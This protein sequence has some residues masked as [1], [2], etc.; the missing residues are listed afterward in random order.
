MS[1]APA[2]PALAVRGLR[3]GYGR[4]GDIVRGID[5]DQLPETI[6]AVIG[7]NGS[8]KSTFVKTLAGLLRPREGSISITGRDVTGLSAARR[9][10]AGVAYVPQEKNVFATLTV[11]ENMQLATEFLRRRAG[12]GRE[13]EERVLT[14]FPELADRG[15]TLAGNLSGGQ[16]QMVAFACALLAN[17]EV[18]LLDEPS[19]GLSPRFVSETMEA[20]VRVRSAGT[21][22]VL[23]EQNVQAALCIADA[24]MVLVA[25]RKSLEAPAGQ[26]RQADLAD[27]FF[28]RAA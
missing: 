5:L 17:P 2:I 28:A 10:V 15:R 18:L 3:A 8:G 26:I 6:L 20:I 13:Q 22:I 24:V 1:G 14:L 11:R 9:V 19:A 16:R 12:T 7:P 4:G 27:L 21:T 25:G 23:V